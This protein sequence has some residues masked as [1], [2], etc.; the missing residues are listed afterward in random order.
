MVRAA[1]TEKQQQ[2]LGLL[3]K[4]KSQNRQF[5]YGM[6]ARMV[7][8]KSRATIAKHITALERYGYVQKLTVGHSVIVLAVDDIST[9]PPPVIRVHERNAIHLSDEL[10]WS[11]FERDNYQCLRCGLRHSLTVDH[12]QPWQLGGAEE[13][14]DNLQTLCRGCNGLKRQ[15]STDYRPK[16]KIQL[17]GNRP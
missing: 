2:L 14:P 1:L 11:I 17:S 9:E 4:A 13:D 5:S 6:M 3:R 12:I 7:G 8:V 16:N 10:R 15:N